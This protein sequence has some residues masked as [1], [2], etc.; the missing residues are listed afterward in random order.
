MTKKKDKKAAK[1]INNTEDK[2]PEEGGAQE[3]PAEPEAD[4]GA[5][6]GASAVT[7]APKSIA[8]QAEKGADTAADASPVA[9]ESVAER[10]ARKAAMMKPQPAP[11]RE[12]RSD[13][14]RAGIWGSPNRSTGFGSPRMFGKRST[15]ESRG[16]AK[17]RKPFRLFGAPRAKA[18]EES[19]ETPNT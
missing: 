12:P 2:A 7:V 15:P 11:R 4:S 1:G 8:A 10:A 14:E 5:K 9:S 18:E 6:K 19:K 17:K 13:A 16:K 3:A